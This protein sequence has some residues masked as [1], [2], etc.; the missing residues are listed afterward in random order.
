[1]HG[2]GGQHGRLPAG[3]GCQGQAFGAAQLAH[4]DP[5]AAG[6]RA[7]PGLGHRDPGARDPVPAR[8]A[9]HHPVGSDGPAGREDC[10]R[11]RSRQLHERRPGGRLRPDRQGTGPPR[12][13]LRAAVAYPATAAGHAG[14]AQMAKATPERGPVPRFLHRNPGSKALAPQPGGSAG[15]ANCFGV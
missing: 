7:R 11:H 9:Q 15:D 13:M 4:H 8:A 3:G 5:P 2:H 10:P 6:R 12:L 14:R 1:M